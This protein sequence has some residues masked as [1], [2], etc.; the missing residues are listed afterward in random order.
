MKR[1]GRWSQGSGQGPDPVGSFRPDKG[2]RICV[3]V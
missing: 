1:T 2:L 3:S